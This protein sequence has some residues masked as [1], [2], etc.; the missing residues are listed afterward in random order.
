MVAVRAQWLI[1]LV[2]MACIAVAGMT[3]GAASSSTVF[4][5]A[6]TGYTALVPARLLDT[7]TGGR[8]IDNQY[9]AIGP[10]GNN[11][12]LDLTVTGRGGVP[13]SGVAAVVLN[14]TA[15]GPTGAGYTTVY[16]TGSPQPDASNLNFAVG[17][18]VPNLVIAKVGTNG[19]VSIY[20]NGGNTNYLADVV[21]WYP[22]AFTVVSAVE[23]GPWHTC[24]IASGQVKCWGGSFAGNLGDGTHNL[25]TTAVPTPVTVNGINDAT[26][27]TLGSLHTCAVRVSGKVNCWG[28]NDSGQLGNGTFDDTGVPAEVAGISNAVAV[29]AGES[30]TCALLA[31][32]T[33][34]CWGDNSLG[35]LGN[36]TQTT[37]T[38]LAVDV[39]GLSNATKLVAGDT[40]TC[41]LGSDQMVRC[42]GKNSNGQLGN[43][44]TDG[45]LAPVTVTGISD[46]IDIAA[47]TTNSCAL[48]ANGTVSCWGLNNY[49]GLGVPG[50][51]NSTT[52]TLVTG[53]SGVTAIGGGGGQI[54]AVNATGV[55]CWGATTANFSGL[56]T[57][58]ASPTLEPGTAGAAAVVTGGPH[59]CAISTRGALQCWGLNNFGQTGTGLTG[60][61]TSPAPVIGL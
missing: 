53:L 7:R 5:V 59:R 42:W 34:K 15:V 55:L 25:S 10:I 47:S 57:I 1:C 51:P 20:N 30:H 28:R 29:A 52:P 12:T 50:S 26:G 11:A 19:K 54:C 27:I 8:T 56:Y 41:A 33:V 14:I 13:P 39:S 36:G 18:V 49:G 37:F 45:A 44:T 22:A 16:P 23:A 17:D 46:A 35:L 4:A 2:A 38:P 32:H 60:G 31:T 3:I 58:D 24:A 48:R 40:H 9:A 6:P 61:Y 43:G 21:G